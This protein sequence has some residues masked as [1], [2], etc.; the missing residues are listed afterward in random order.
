MENLEEKKPAVDH[1]IKL[2]KVVKASMKP[3]KTDKHG[4][5]NSIIEMFTEHIDNY[6]EISQQLCRT[7]KGKTVIYDLY[8]KQ[9]EENL[10]PHINDICD[11]KKHMVRDADP[12]FNTRCNI[13][14]WIG[15]DKPDK[16][17][18]NY[19]FRVTNCYKYAVTQAQICEDT[20]KQN[21]IYHRQLP[22]LATWEIKYHFISYLIEAYTYNERKVTK[23]VAIQ[24]KLKTLANMS[25]EQT[26]DQAKECFQGM[27]QMGGTLLKT[28][29]LI[30]A[31]SNTDDMIPEITH[32]V[33]ELMTGTLATTLKDVVAGNTT[34][35]DALT[36]FIPMLTSQLGKMPRPPGV[37]EEGADDEADEE[38]FDAVGMANEMKGGL[39]QIMGAMG[40]FTGA[41]KPK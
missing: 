19:R 31:D 37:H 10:Q 33:T 13:E 4:K 39:D 20:L 29:G 5:S 11:V 16:K 30:D 12:F 7:E 28:M 6:Q 34:P 35:S 3:A 1:N 26:Q 25:T 2:C 36:D 17:A 18:K 23:L 22:Y 24:S 32:A 9:Y 41:K 15:E 27:T 8:I 14:L 40:N 38:E 21:Q